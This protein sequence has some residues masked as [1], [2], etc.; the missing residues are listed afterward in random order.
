MG[1]RSTLRNPHMTPYLFG[2]R[3]GVDVFDLEQTSEL[4][5]DALNFTAHIA[6]RGGIILFMIQHRQVSYCLYH[7]LHFI[8]HIEI[9]AR[10]LSL[11]DGLSRVNDENVHFQLKNVLSKTVSWINRSSPNCGNN[12]TAVLLIGL[13]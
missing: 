5:F 3:Q 2:T 1:H 9:A 8:P 10:G 12:L 11:S 7:C 13:A 6:Y 4:L